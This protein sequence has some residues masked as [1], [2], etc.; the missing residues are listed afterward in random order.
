MEVQDKLKQ[1]KQLQE[2][3]VHAVLSAQGSVFIIEPSSEVAKEMASYGVKVD[4][5]HRIQSIVDMRID[6]DAVKIMIDL[7]REL[8]DEIHQ[9]GEELMKQQ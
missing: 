2:K 1:I 9:Y 8:Q 7:I 5:K 6:A 4:E 3:V